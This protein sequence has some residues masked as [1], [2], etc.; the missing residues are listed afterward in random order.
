MCVA[1][2][3]IFSAGSAIKKYSSIHFSRS[4]PSALRLIYGVLGVHANKHT[5]R[6]SSYLYISPTLYLSNLLYFTPEQGSSCELKF[7]TR[8]VRNY[9]CVCS[10][11]CDWNQDIAHF[12]SPNDDSYTSLLFDTFPPLYNR[13]SN[14]NL[15]K[16]LN[17]RSMNTEWSKALSEPCCYIPLSSIRYNFLTSF[18]L[19]PTQPTLNQCSPTHSTFKTISVYNK[20]I[21]KFLGALTFQVRNSRVNVSFALSQAPLGGA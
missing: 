16:I 17:S 13:L 5:H 21:S 11:I 15:I 6:Y 10:S 19:H 3:L 18:V 4:C 12:Q 1:W 9:D 20:T 7:R 8:S 2:K 14:Q